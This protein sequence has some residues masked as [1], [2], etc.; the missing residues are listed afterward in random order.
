M[1]KE[2]ER[3][4]QSAAEMAVDLER[5]L[6]GEAIS[7]RPA[8]FAYRM[9]KK[10]RKHRAALMAVSAVIALSLGGTAGYTAWQRE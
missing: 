5:F 6:E 4:Y 10:V 7:A 3:R 2:P 1:F 9:G 8:S